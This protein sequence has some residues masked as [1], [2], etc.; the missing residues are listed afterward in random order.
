MINCSFKLIAAA[1][2]FACDSTAILSKFCKVTLSRK[3]GIKGS[4]KISLHLD[5]RIDKYQ[6]RNAVDI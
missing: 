2:G 1:R 3:F 4:L 6:T 5:S